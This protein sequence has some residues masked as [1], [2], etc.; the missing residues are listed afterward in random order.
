MTKQIPHSLQ[1]ER[2][3]EKTQQSQKEMILQHLL[4]G[5]KLT[6]LDGLIYF[7]CMKTS[8]RISELKR[9]GWQ[10]E[11]AIIDTKSHKRIA[12]YSMPNKKIDQRR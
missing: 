8:N 9:E 11:T 6:V 5:S 12:E 3:D 1:S 4:T 2:E 10:I 7:N